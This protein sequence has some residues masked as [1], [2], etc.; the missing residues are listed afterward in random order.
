MGLFLIKVVWIP[1]PFPPLFIYTWKIND[2]KTQDPGSYSH[3]KPSSMGI[4]FQTPQDFRGVSNSGFKQ[5]T[6]WA[7]WGIWVKG[8]LQQALL[9]WTKKNNCVSQCLDTCLSLY[10]LN[11]S[12]W[13]V[14]GLGRLKAKAWS[15]RKINLNLT[16]K[17]DGWMII[18]EGIC[19]SELHSISITV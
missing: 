16:S 3:W 18:R 2:P 19:I 4:S 12:H 10:V 7:R 15:L 14:A 13:R 17:A 6:L 11:G 5:V 9:Y 8:R 1:F